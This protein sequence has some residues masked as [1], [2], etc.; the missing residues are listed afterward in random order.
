MSFDTVNVTVRTVHKSF[1][2]Y[3]KPPLAVNKYAITIAVNDGLHRYHV[4]RRRMHDAPSYG[5]RSVVLVDIP[6]LD[7]NYLGVSGT[8]LA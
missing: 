4:I 2:L 5:R 8:P 6:V 3:D 1:F 7:V